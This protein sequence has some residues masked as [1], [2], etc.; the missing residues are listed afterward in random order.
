MH[1]P[2]SLEDFQFKWNVIDLLF[3]LMLLPAFQCHMWQ[4]YPSTTVSYWSGMSILWSDLRLPDTFWK[5]WMGYL[6]RND[7]FAYPPPRQEWANHKISDFSLHNPCSLEDFYF[8]WNVIGLLFM[9][10]SFPAFQCHMRQ[11]CSYTTVSFWSG[12]IILWW[13]LRLPDSF[14]KYWMGYLSRNDL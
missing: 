6:S 14:W 3:M 11:H 2:Y 5:Y 7:R 4:N 1:N 13:D 8:N 10:M 12:M 9:L